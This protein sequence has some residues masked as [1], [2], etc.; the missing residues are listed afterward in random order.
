MER[1]SYNAGRVLGAVGEWLKQ[2]VV[3]E[4]PAALKVAEVKREV[5]DG[6]AN[7]QAAGQANRSAQEPAKAQSAAPAKQPDKEPQQLKVNDVLRV[8][9]LQKEKR[10]LLKKGQRNDL[11]PKKNKQKAKSLSVR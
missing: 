2:Q 5:R 7:G 8:A 11:L 9:D 6:L 1:L 3:A 10:Q 4:K